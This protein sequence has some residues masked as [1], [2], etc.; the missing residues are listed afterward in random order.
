[1]RAKPRQLEHQEQV[2]LFQ[3]VAYNET[4]Y[5][6]LRNLFAVPNGG[7]RHVAVAVKLKKE[8]VKRGVP[9]IFLAW[10]SNNMNGLFIEMKAGSKPSPDQKEWHARLR[11]ANYLVAVCYGSA[12]AIKTIV[13]YLNLPKRL[14]ANL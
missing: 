11:A 10:P 14:L 5:P 12:D 3:W 7:Q 1:M 6:E 4:N 9:D 13:Y 8:G 2:A